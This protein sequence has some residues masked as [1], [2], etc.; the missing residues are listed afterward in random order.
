MYLLSNISIL[1]IYDKFQG[2]RPWKEM[3]LM[4]KTT[5][6]RRPAVQVTLCLAERLRCQGQIATSALDRIHPA[7][8]GGLDNIGHRCG[9]K[10]TQKYTQQKTSLKCFI[11]IQFVDLVAHKL[12][13]YDLRKNDHEMAR[14]CHAS[15]S[16]SMIYEGMSLKFPFQMAIADRNK[17][18]T[19]TPN[20][21]TSTM[22]TPWV[23]GLCR[24]PGRCF[25]HSPGKDIQC[26]VDPISLEWPWKTQAGSENHPLLLERNPAITS[27]GRQ[28]IRL[29][30]GFYVSQVVQDFFHQ[31]YGT[32][33]PPIM[34]V[35]RHFSNDLHSLKLRVRRWKYFSFSNHW[36][37]G[38][39]L[40]SGRVWLNKNH[41]SNKIKDMHI[42]LVRGILI[43]TQ[44][45][46]HMVRKCSKNILQCSVA[47]INVTW[48]IEHPQFQKCIPCEKSGIQ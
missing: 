21:K 30:I 37:S 46:Q 14:M 4:L 45:H 1:S 32:F 12:M 28:F 29:F 19:S 26:L 17:N 23:P 9:P 39:I 8:A 3:H 34:V 22:P 5:R 13:K 18:N 25:A 44:V 16:F 40:V 33:W 42:K 48:A 43:K 24:C 6:M 7:K 36:F 11:V 38:A 35:N 20:P 27:W 10:P 15:M 41:T 31:Q 47:T 2:V